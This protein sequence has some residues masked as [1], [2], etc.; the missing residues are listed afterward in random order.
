MGVGEQVNQSIAVARNKDTLQRSRSGI[1]DHPLGGDQSV[2]DTVSEA[3]V[4]F[5]LGQP[6]FTVKRWQVMMFVRRIP[7]F[8]KFNAAEVLQNPHHGLDISFT[9]QQIQVADVT[10]TGIHRKRMQE[11]GRPFQRDDANILL[12]TSLADLGQLQ[13][14]FSISLKIR[15]LHFGKEDI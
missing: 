10:V 2:H 3:I 14:K 9:D 11:F 7:T 4:Q 13:R 15:G 1:F 8:N 5:D 6:I 12:G